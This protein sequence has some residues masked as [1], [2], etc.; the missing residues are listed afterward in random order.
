MFVMVVFDPFLGQSELFLNCSHF[1][2]TNFV[3]EG[4]EVVF[5]PV[6]VS[7]VAVSELVEQVD[8]DVHLSHRVLVLFNF[9]PLAG[10][11]VLD[12]AELEG[13]YAGLYR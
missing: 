1:F 4:R 8:A 10:G 6:E 12:V 7:L 11:L 13:S 3:C 9:I 2:L 5:A